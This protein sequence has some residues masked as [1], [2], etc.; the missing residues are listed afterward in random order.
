MVGNSAQG[1]GRLID[2]L[3]LQGAAIDQGQTCSYEVPVLYLLPGLPPVG[4]TILLIPRAL[5]GLGEPVWP[6][7]SHGAGDV[8]V[9]VGCILIGDPGHV[10]V[11]LGTHPK[12][13]QFGGDKLANHDQLGVPRQAVGEGQTEF[14]E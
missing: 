5:L 7:A 14:A 6:Q 3:G 13:R 11:D 1:Q 4:D 9:R 12:W 8:G 10:E 2:T